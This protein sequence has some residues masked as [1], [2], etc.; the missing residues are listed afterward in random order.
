MRLDSLYKEYDL[1]TF[2]KV[3]SNVFLKNVNDN[4]NHY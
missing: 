3:L 4:E 2:D 1:K